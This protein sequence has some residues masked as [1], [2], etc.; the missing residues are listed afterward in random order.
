MDSDEE[1]N[2]PGSGPTACKYDLHTC[3]FVSVSY[4]DGPKPV[5]LH[6]IQHVTTWRLC[7]HKGDHVVRR[8]KR[9]PQTMGVGLVLAWC[10]LGG[11]SSRP[12]VS[13]VNICRPT[14]VAADINRADHRVEERFLG[15]LIRKYG[16]GSPERKQ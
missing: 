8:G 13:P 14:T 16:H 11:S 15:N 2:Y 6:T 9:T 10:W 4:G 12:A 3:W 7:R 1:S 5:F